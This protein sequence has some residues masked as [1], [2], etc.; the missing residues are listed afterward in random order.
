MEERGVAGGAAHHPLRKSWAV[1][2]AVPLLLLP[3]DQQNHLHSSN[4]FRL[5]FHRVCREKTSLQAGVVGEEAVART[6]CL[7][8]REP[9]RTP[10]PELFRLLAI[11]RAPLRKDQIHL[12][13]S[14]HWG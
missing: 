8:A 11:R 14:S 2:G 3:Q 7:W 1:E 5:P 4:Y 6:S 10:L 12:L 9:L 13:P